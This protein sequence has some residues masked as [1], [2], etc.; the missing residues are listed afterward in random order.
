MQ[1][2]NWLGN[3]YLYIVNPTHEFCL[4]KASLNDSALWMFAG[5]E[6]DAFGWWNAK[7][8][9]YFDVRGNKYD[10]W[11]WLDWEVHNI[12]QWC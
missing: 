8:M 3:G 10:N 2:G 9:M 1:R 5:I 4:F 12:T 11:F 6:G 7:C